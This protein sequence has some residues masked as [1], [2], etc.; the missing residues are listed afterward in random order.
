MHSDQVTYLRV[1]L[2][3]NELKKIKL[4]EAVDAVDGDGQG[5]CDDRYEGN[6]AAHDDL[7]VNHA[8]LQNP[9]Q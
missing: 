7:Q 6:G 4:R 9:A 2:S 3:L 1:N 5:G 8:S